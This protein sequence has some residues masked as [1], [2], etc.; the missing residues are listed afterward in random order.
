MAVATFSQQSK[1]K[2]K[3]FY[4][5][6]NFF[7][8]KTLAVRINNQMSLHTL[9][10]RGDNYTTAI[11]AEFRDKIFQKYPSLKFQ[12]MIETY[13]YQVER[14]FYRN[15]QNKNGDDLSTFVGFE[16]FGDKHYNRCMDIQTCLTTLVFP[17]SFMLPDTLRKSC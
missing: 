10:L 9:C 2:H 11:P 1:N 3:H 15:I 4:F 12:E 14:A 5:F 7:V 16:D 6:F 17:T 13:D 8:A